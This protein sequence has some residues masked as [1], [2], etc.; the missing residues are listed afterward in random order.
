M[1]KILILSLF[2]FSSIALAGENPLKTS[3]IE[4]LLKGN[5]S[6]GVHYKERTSQYFSKSGLTLWIKSGDNF[7]S[8]GQWKAENDKYCSDFGNGWNCYQIS[9][10]KE[11]GIYYFLSDNFRAPFIMKEGYV[12]TP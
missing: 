5:T 10:D 8:E 7:P 12:P 11:Q 1:K 6:N 9:E 2:T 3:E 4:T